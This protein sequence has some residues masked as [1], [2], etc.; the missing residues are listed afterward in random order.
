MTDTLANAK[1]VVTFWREAGPER[2]F[3]KDDAFDT[4]IKRRFLPTY[5]AAA[6]G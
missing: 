1:D 3:K 6:A 5:E 2:W 4:E